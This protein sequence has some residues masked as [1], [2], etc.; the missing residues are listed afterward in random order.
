MGV[1]ILSLFDIYDFGPI[2]GNFFVN[3]LGMIILPILYV[4]LAFTSMR[5]KESNTRGLLILDK[6]IIVLGILIYVSLILFGIYAS[7]LLNGAS[8]G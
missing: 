8:I 5:N 2:L 1:A 4:S 6:A 7:M 3:V